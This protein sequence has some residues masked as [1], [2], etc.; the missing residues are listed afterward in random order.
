MKSLKIVQLIAKV[1]SVLTKIAFV[2]CIIAGTLLLVGAIILM[3]Y[4]EAGV[5]IAESVDLEGI[6]NAYAD[7]SVAPADVRTGVLIATPFVGAILLAL[8]ITVAGAA[9]VVGFVDSYFKFE[10]GEGTPF[11]HRGANKLFTIGILGIAIPVGTAIVSSIIIST[12][13]NLAIHAF[14]EAVEYLGGA[15]FSISFGANLTLGISALLLSFV[16]RYGAD[17]EKKLQAPKE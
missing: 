3:T 9:V 10:L 15:Q 17:L 11:T 13:L 16:F 4:P 1:L 8:A 2:C 7:G 14:P 5:Q 12:A 6:I